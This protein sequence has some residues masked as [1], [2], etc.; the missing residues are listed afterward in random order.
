METFKVE[1]KEYIQKA[2]VFL[3]WGNGMIIFI[4]NWGSRFSITK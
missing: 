2:A 4:Q 1:R 3:I